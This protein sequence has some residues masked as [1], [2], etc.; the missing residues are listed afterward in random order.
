MQ[1]ITKHDEM[2]RV[3]D[4]YS[5]NAN[6]NKSKNIETSMLWSLIHHNIFPRTFIHYFGLHSYACHI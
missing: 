6:D 3:A 2:P 4:R 1:L 5:D